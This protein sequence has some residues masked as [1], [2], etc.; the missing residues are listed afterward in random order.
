MNRLLLEK[1]VQISH[2]HMKRWSTLLII[3]E[4]QIKTLVRC[5]FYL[6]EKQAP[7]RQLLAK[8]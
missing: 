7:P 4:L 5:H 6:V 2:K 3:R 8:V 1:E